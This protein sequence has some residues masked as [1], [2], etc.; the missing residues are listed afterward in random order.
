MD[1]AMRLTFVAATYLWILLIAGCAVQGSA[2][3]EAAWVERVAAH[4]ETFKYYPRDAG[5]STNRPDGTVTVSL[6]MDRSG[7]IATPVVSQSSGSPLLDAAALALVLAANPLPPPPSSKDQS[8]VALLLPVRYSAP[9]ITENS[10]RRSSRAIDDP[11]WIE[12]VSAHLT[13]FKYYPRDPEHPT[14]AVTVRIDIDRDG[15]I[16]TPIVTKSSGSP[17]LDAA[18]LTLVLT[19][20]PLPPPPMPDG[21]DRAA[22][23]LPVVFR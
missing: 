14:G 15:R 13:K 22:V 21:Q 11:A 16:A 6:S 20:N 1:R 12:R 18:A 2:R 7:R 4:L 19:A 5:D 17:L 23:L 9:P 8:R 10:P 3:D